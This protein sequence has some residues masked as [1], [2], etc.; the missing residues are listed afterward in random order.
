MSI[1]APLSDLSSRMG[2]RL[3]Q[4]NCECSDGILI[5]NPHS[6]LIKSR[7]SFQILMMNVVIPALYLA[8]AVRVMSNFQIGESMP[9]IGLSLRKK[10]CDD[11]KITS[12]PDLIFWSLTESLIYWK[13]KMYC[14]THVVCTLG[15]EVEISWSFKRKCLRLWV[16]STT[17][18]VQTDEIPV[19]SLE[20]DKVWPIFGAINV[21]S[22]QVKFEILDKSSDFQDVTKSVRFSSAGGKMDI[23]TDGKT[24]SRSSKGNGNSVA[25]LN[26]VIK[27]GTHHWKLD[28]ISD[29][30]AS[31]GIGLAMHNFQL[32]EKYRQDPLRHVYHHKGLFLW[33]SYRGFLYSQ[34]QQLPY[35]LE[36]LGWQNGPPISIELSL[37]MKEGTLE[38]FKNGKSLGIAFTDIQGPVQPAVAFY[39]AYEKE[40]RLVEFRSSSMFDHDVEPDAAVRVVQSDKVAFDPKSLKGKLKLADDGMTLY[41]QREQSGNAFCLLNATLLNGFHRWS[42]VIQ[43][44]QGASTC[45]GVAKEPILLNT[46]GNIYT[47]PNLYVLRSFQGIL[48]CEGRELKKRCS[49]FW[50]SGSLI[51]VSFEVNSQG[52]GV[53]GYA[54][55]GED[56]GIAFTNINPPVRP[57]IGFYAGMEKKVTLVHYEHKPLA[58]VDND[59]N[60]EHTSHS[61]K[62]NPLPI[63]IRPKDVSLYCDICMV[64][65]DEV[66]VIALPC[67]H[68]TLCA[69]HLA[70]DGSQSCLVCDQTITGVWNILLK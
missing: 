17:G 70:S 18:D 27:E 3:S 53:L 10:S 32:S 34:G 69:D 50:L 24:I 68:S 23:S 40:V 67:K 64:C 14:R 4:D 54:I 37:K 61:V 25:L 28:V 43:N 5:T 44:D 42:F 22:E 56:Q 41:R 36:P 15:C 66:C 31:I 26:K 16:K 39:A 12:D 65:G 62:H 29:F 38:I 48:Y 60:K 59:L 55:N 19:E 45:V 6:F 2:S 33:R 30:G 46:T 35:S 51:E 58:K 20:F 47:S 11:I 21:G 57:F 63:F 52:G 1:T 7:R 49:E 13:G 9:F 8:V